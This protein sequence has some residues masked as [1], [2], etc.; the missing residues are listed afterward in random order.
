VLGHQIA[1]RQ[2]CLAGPYGAVHRIL[3]VTGLLTWFDVHDTMEEAVS[4]SGTQ[5]SSGDLQNPAW[6]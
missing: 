6:A 5:A 3:V 4:R 2:F 1:G